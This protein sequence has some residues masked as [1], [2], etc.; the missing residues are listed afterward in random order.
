MTVFKCEHCSKEFKSKESLKMH[1]NAKHV[2]AK[3][4]RFFFDKKF[5]KTLKIFSI[6][7][8][9][10]FSLVFLFNFISS[11]AY[12]CN[13]VPAEVMNI[14]SHNNLATHIHQIIE[15]SILGNK[16]TIPSNIGLGTD[17]MSPI[18]THESGGELHNEA[19][20]F[21][22]FVLGDFFKIWG[23][24]FN[25]T[26]IFDNCVSLNHSLKIFVNGFENLEF[27]N[28]TLKD[29]DNIR[30]VFSEVN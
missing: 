19:P 9:G 15:I 2:I 28:L 7:F 30:I 14:V 11:K 29:G 5:V 27:E 3:K 18:H 4:E 13:T 17:W 10:L 12:D 20:C 24:N 22:T 26:C 25:S 6:I 23:K 16:Y 8:L 1:S 21:R